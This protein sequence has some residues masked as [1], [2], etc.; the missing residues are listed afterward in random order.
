MKNVNT[1][2]TVSQT[3]DIIVETLQDLHTNPAQTDW[4]DEWSPYTFIGNAMEKH[5]S[6]NQ[7]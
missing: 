2:L 6:T 7:V 5:G 1:K 4:K 3:V